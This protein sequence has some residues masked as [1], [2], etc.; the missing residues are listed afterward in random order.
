MPDET[1]TSKI[2]DIGFRLS[3]WNYKR[4]KGQPD[5]VPREGA[6]QWK[7]AFPSVHVSRK[8]S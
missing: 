4:F 1:E 8:P 5:A 6:G 7:G 2:Q 3:K